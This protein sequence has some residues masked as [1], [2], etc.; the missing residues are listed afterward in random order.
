LEEFMSIELWNGFCAGMSVDDVKNRGDELFGFDF[1]EETGFS[2][3]AE[4]RFPNE[5]SDD[6]VPQKW[7]NKITPDTVI[8][9]GYDDFR[10]ARVPEC[11]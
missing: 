9:Y 7:F 6:R 1:S 4:S 2:P 8:T 11:L 10:R 3:A 5:W